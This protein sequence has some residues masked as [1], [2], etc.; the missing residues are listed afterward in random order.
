MAKKTKKSKPVLASV[1]SDADFHAEND[2][3][4]LIDAEKIKKDK[5][6]MSAA[7]K[8]G[9]EQRVALESV[10]DKKKET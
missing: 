6:R 9:K 7:L 8:K 10:I 1:T 3:R 2:M 4:T 5:G